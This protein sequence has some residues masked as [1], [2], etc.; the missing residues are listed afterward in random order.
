[1]K[2]NVFIIAVV[3]CLLALGR[4]G[5][6]E[7]LSFRGTHGDGVSNVELPKKCDDENVRWTADLPGQGV[8]SPI[9]VGQQVI[10]TASSGQRQD[11]LHVI[12]IDAQTGEENWHRQFWATGRTLTHESS[13]NAAPTPTS[14]GEHIVAFFSSNDLICLGLDGDLI[15]YRGLGHD[16]PKA[17]NDLGMASSPLIAAGVVVCQAE[18]M[19]DSFVEGIDVQTGEQLWRLERPLD[20]HWSSPV[21][22]KGD[23]DLVLLKNSK[24]V[25]AHDIKTGEVV[26]RVDGEFGSTSSMVVGEQYIYVPGDRFTVLDRQP[27][28]VT[29]AWDSTKI[30]PS[31]SPVLYGEQLFA[32]NGAGVLRCFDARNGD[33]SWQLRVGGKYWATPVFADGHVYMINDQGELSIIKAG[34]EGIKLDSHDFGE[35]VMGSPAASDGALFVR[36]RNHLWKVAN[37]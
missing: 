25:A 27:S 14:D 34:E 16:Y 35:N 33:L 32:V 13:A 21:T 22:M 30:D 15:W 17:G 11:R 4:S 5:L 23:V 8:S 10:V 18:N 6:A 20:S 37:P 24:N 28:S 7:W 31:T 9:V 2:K 26:W 1:M 12:S 29:V 36:S 3:Y 19:G